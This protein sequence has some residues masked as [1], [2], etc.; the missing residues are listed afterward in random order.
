MLLVKWFLFTGIGMG[1]VADSGICAGTVLGCGKVLV[2]VTLVLV[3]L[4]ILILL[5]VLELMS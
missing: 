1:I 3:M 4:V 5:L 2:L